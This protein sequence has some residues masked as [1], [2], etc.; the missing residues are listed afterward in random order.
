MF[1][2]FS[3]ENSLFALNSVDFT[4]SLDVKDKVWVMVGYRNTSGAILG[5]GLKRSNFAVA[6]SYELD[7]SPMALVSSG[8]HEV[9]AF[10]RI[11]TQTRA[12]PA[13]W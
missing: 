12:K 11:G 5:I 1:R 4:L 10:Y 13:S 8:T 9:S 2:Q 6:Y 7:M 3:I